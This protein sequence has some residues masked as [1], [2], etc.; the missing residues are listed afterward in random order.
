MAARVSVVMLTFQMREQKETLGLS[1]MEK[2][3][4]WWIC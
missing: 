4:L 2:K 1:K 3:Q